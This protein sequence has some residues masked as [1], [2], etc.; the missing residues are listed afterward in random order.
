MSNV[1]IQI[2]GLYY[3]IKLIFLTYNYCI[4]ILYIVFKFMDK[5]PIAVLPGNL[6]NSWIIGTEIDNINFND[7]NDKEFFPA[8]A[9]EKKAIDDA[10]TKKSMVYA[11]NGLTCSS[12]VQT[13]LKYNKMEHICVVKHNDVEHSFSVRAIGDNNQTTFNCT[14]RPILIVK[15]IKDLPKHNGYKWPE[16]KDRDYDEV[17]LIKVMKAFNEF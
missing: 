13:P 4:I 3:R 15:D 14:P 9:R 10:L 5:K 11:K 17:E 8:T 7:Y 12:L 1:I 2:V 16:D 6:P